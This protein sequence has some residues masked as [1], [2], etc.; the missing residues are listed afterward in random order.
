MLIGCRNSLLV[1]VCGLWV[2]CTQYLGGASGW[3]TDL[4]DPDVMVEFNRTGLRESKLSAKAA[5]SAE[6]Y[7]GP[8]SPQKN[9][10][11]TSLLPLPTRGSRSLKDHPE[12]S[13]KGSEYVLE[14]GILG[15]ST[16]DSQAEQWVPEGKSEV[17]G[18]RYFLKPDSMSLEEVD[19]EVPGVLS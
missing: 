5:P 14:D 12:K 2:H 3:G 4:L 9:L 19:T 10:G 1:K 7:S 11:S 8:S 16:P 13:S 17:H 18:G 15:E 6:D